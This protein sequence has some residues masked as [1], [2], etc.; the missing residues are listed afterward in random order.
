MPEAVLHVEWRLNRSEHI[1]NKAY[2]IVLLLFVLFDGGCSIFH[3]KQ[4]KDLNGSLHGGFWEGNDSNFKS[5]YWGFTFIESQNS[6]IGTCF[7]GG[8]DGVCLYFLDDCTINGDYF[9]GRMTYPPWK[10]EYRIEGVFN[11]TSCC[12]TQHYTEG[13]CVVKLHRVEKLKQAPN[14]FKSR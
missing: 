5:Y 1:M 14:I 8:K 10:V 11:G 12:Y 3:E 7:Q 2:T 9:K 4:S 13:Y 6:L